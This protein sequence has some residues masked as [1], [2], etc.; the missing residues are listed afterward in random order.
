MSVSSSVIAKDID[1][2]GGIRYIEERHTIND[3]SVRIVR[4]QCPEGFDKAAR[5]AAR[6]IEINDRLAAEEFEGLVE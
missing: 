4:Y 2:G 6:V 3:G 5:M 1:L